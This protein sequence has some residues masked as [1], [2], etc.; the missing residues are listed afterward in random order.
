M[1]TNEA[2]MQ[3]ILD[4]NDDSFY[5]E[6]SMYKGL[7][8]MDFWAKWCGPCQLFLKVLNN[9]C[10]IYFNKMKFTKVNIDNV[11]KLTKKFNIKSVPTL[12]LFRN[13]IVLDKQIGAL[14]EDDVISFFKKNG[15]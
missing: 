9:L 15:I 4:I 5:K 8:L 10:K 11:V 1:I 6:V 7:V 12:I 13:G 2:C 3:K 14:S